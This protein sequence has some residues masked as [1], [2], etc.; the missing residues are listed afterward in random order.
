MEQREAHLWFGVYFRENRWPALKHSQEQNPHPT[1]VG[2]CTGTPSPQVST[3][4]TGH[5]AISPDAAQRTPWLDLLSAALTPGWHTATSATHAMCAQSIRC[6]SCLWRR[7]L[8]KSPA[9]GH[10]P[11]G[12]SASF[13]LQEYLGSKV[14]CLMEEG[15]YLL[16]RSSSVKF[17][18]FGKRV[19]ILG[20][21]K[22]SEGAEKNDKFKF[23]EQWTR[24]ELGQLHCNQSCWMTDSL[25]SFN[26]FRDIPLWG[27]VPV[28]SSIYSQISGVHFWV[29]K[30]LLK[31]SSSCR[32]LFPGLYT[33]M[34]LH[35]NF[36]KLGNA[37]ERQ[38]QRT[39]KLLHNSTHLTC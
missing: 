1:R 18:S 31:T 19:Q 24:S 33:D 5:S 4:T 6:G 11:G 30:W 37:K 25:M 13:Y 9:C 23:F 14:F 17:P 8:S 34:L 36:Y 7:V 29:M 21:E 2:S 38:C 35:V 32:C 20:L 12:A 22:E 27:P 3:D 28:H 26:F 10:L 15:V 39:F 16:P